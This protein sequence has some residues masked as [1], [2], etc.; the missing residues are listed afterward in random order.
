MDSIDKDPEFDLDNMGTTTQE[1]AIFCSYLDN[2]KCVFSN[3]IKEGIL[4]FLS[5]S[6]II[7]IVILHGSLLELFFL[8]FFFHHKS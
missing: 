7:T 8:T 1:T 5:T 4:A 6:M 3:A 2:K